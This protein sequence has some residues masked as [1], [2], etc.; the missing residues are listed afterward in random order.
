[1]S[2]HLAAALN[3]N[4]THH[5]GLSLSDYEVLVH[6][7]AAP[8][9][10]LRAFQLGAALEWEKSRLSH[11]VRRMQDRGLV[12]R[13]HCKTDARGM[14]VELT[15]IGHDAIEA[16]APHHVEDVRRYMVDAL[17]PDHLKALAEISEKVLA[18]LPTPG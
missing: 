8:D 3:R 5:T 4:L 18:G 15:P 17:T 1:M 11:H 13:R 12:A 14:W 9:R 6:L 7:S 2:V 16:A 10:R